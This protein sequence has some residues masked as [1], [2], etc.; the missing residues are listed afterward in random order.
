MPLHDT[1]S[2]NLQI[3][4]VEVRPDRK[5]RLTFS[6]GQIGLWK[7][8][9]VGCAAYPVGGV[10]AFPMT[11]DTG[12]SEHAK[13][14]ILTHTPNQVF[15]WIW[16]APRDGWSLGTYA[17]WT[18]WLSYSNEYCDRP[19]D[20]S[21]PS[22]DQTV[23][24]PV[25]PGDESGEESDPIPPEAPAPEPGPPAEPPPP[26]EWPPEEGL[27]PPPP[28]EPEPPPVP[29]PPPPP[30]PPGWEPPLPPED[31]IPPPAPPEPPPPPPP[32]PPEPEPPPPP[33]PA[34]PAPPVDDE[35]PLP[36]PAPFPPGGEEP[37]FDAPIPPPPHLPPGYPVPPDPRDP[38]RYRLVPGGVSAGLSPSMPS[39]PTPFPWATF[40][41]ARLPVVTAPNAQEGS[42]AGLIT[43][44][45]PGT[46]QIVGASQDPASSSLDERRVSSQAGDPAWD[47]VP[48]YPPSNYPVSIHD[49]S[50]TY[51]D[52]TLTPVMVGRIVRKGDRSMLHVAISNLGTEA[53]YRYGAEVMDSAG[54]RYTLKA[55][56]NKTVPAGM[57]GISVAIHW[58]RISTG[59]ARVS[60]FIADS[61]GNPLAGV[62]QDLIVLA[63]DDVIPVQSLEAGAVAGAGSRVT[64]AIAGAMAL[65]GGSTLPLFSSVLLDQTAPPRF[66]V[67]LTGGLL[68]CVVKIASAGHALGFFPSLKIYSTADSATPILT[69][70]LPISILG[71]PID[72]TYHAVGLRDSLSNGRYVIEVDNQAAYDGP[73]FQFHIIVD[74]SKAT[75]KTFVA[76]L[77][78]SAG[79]LVGSI[80]TAYANQ[81]LR[82]KNL[83]TEE[84]VDVESDELGD[85]A[86]VSVPSS[87][88][89]QVG[90][91]LRISHAGVHGDFLGPNT[92]VSETQITEGL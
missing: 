24:E 65:T 89:V 81:T 29:P 58:N 39:E 4:A 67:D 38:N 43:P 14:P 47:F 46:S 53:D 52:L 57:S 15:T 69:S 61:D 21:P 12:D 6:I 27:P 51:E 84:Y 36:P 60:L 82:I 87:L 90:D 28:P 92:T 49:L 19:S 86:D 56:T 74:P 62:Q 45:T 23:T 66:V 91:M 59:R 50:D 22:N 30:P 85:V 33:P 88:D 31:E 32:L 76:D 7:A 44:V 77:S 83:R 79:G 64:D 75:E 11:P 17:G 10:A 9:R 37:P 68:S 5:V 16:D 20:T 48:T 2:S 78:E 35:S 25:A 40:E 8:L 71:V 26:P 41:S 80:E 55:L 72:E 70:V 42:G 13:E 73:E 34:P 63:P 18:F 3:L 54:L 1:Y